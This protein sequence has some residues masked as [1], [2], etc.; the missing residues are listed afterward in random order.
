MTAAHPVS[1]RDLKKHHVHRRIA[2]AAMTLAAERGVDEISAEDI[3][4]R[5]EVGRA[6]FFRYFESK[7][8]A[9]IAGFYEQRLT[10]LVEVLGSA[11]S[12]LRPMDAVIW[13]FRQL[14]VTTEREL[15]LV[16]L[17]ARM[18]NASTALRAKALEFHSRYEAAI[19]AAVAGRFTPSRP[20][21]LRPRLLAAATLAVVQ[22]AVE[23]WATQRQGQD[24]AD[25]VTSALEHL[26]SG[27]TESA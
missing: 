23:H 20:H 17:H 6:T 1:L 7:E 16:R 27:F 22:T 21:D 18:V 26:Q 24:V 4:G 11:P 12:Q 19:A 15:K 14:R 3:A 5:A 25:I 9:V 13:T 10:A 8:A 2:E